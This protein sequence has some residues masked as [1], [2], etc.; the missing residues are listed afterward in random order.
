MTLLQASMVAV[1]IHAVAMSRVRKRRR[2]M[3]R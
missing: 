3:R 1:F 2:R